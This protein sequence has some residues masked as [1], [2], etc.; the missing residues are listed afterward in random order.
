[1]T[2]A[3]KNLYDYQNLNQKAVSKTINLNDK[4]KAK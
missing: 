4:I 3:C 1:M 2:V